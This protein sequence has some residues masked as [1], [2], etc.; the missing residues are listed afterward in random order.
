MTYLRFL[1]ENAQWLGAGFLLIFMSGI[2]Q[3][4]F[5]AIFTGAIRDE[6]GLSHGQWGGIYSLATAASA[7]LML[8]F[9]GVADR[10][11]ARWLGTAV[12]LG[13]ALAC[14]MVSLAQGLVALA[15]AV[16]L[17]RFLGLGMTAHVALVATA[18]WFARTRGK[19]VAVVM[20]GFAFSEAILPVAFVAALETTD[21]RILWR[22]MAGMVLVGAVLLPLI[23]RGERIPA[24]DEVSGEQV[25]MGGVHW[26]RGR[27]LKHWL[28]W[29]MAP[30]VVLMPAAI[31]GF[32]FHQVHFSALAGVEHVAFVAL[33]PPFTIALSLCSFAWG[34]ATDRWGLA[35]LFPWSLLPAAAGFACFAGAEGIGLIA[36]GMLGVAIS[37]SGQDVLRTAFWPEY[38]GTR[39]LGSIKSVAMALVVL[40]TAI[41]PGLSGVLIDLG[42]GLR[43]QFAA[44]VVLMLIAN[45]AIKI[46]LTR[47][48]PLL[49]VPA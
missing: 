8:T 19:A 34:W 11:G 46:G 41:G 23:L 42:V 48:R 20:S 35:V 2:A 43:V 12:L 17:L 5:V 37:F 7:V 16:F 27:V 6:F 36:L 18:R 28:F 26:T 24:G 1:R 49:A 21:W 47:A 22:V 29:M 9:G 39:H 3:T 44:V 10:F 32:F 45:A 14:L 30:S 40:G 4:S 25:G 13:L 31:S 15:A 38:F 33:F